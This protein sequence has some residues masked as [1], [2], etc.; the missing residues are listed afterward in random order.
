[1]KMLKARVLGDNV[2]EDGDEL[3][4]GDDLA[5]ED[6]VNIVVRIMMA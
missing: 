5:G 3:V 4:D 1:M 6:D 2:G